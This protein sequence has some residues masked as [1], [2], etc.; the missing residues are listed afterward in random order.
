MKKMLFFLFVG[1]IFVAFT[2]VSHAS[3]GWCGNIWPLHDATV[4]DNVDVGVYFQIWK[5][6]VTTPAGQGAGIGASLFY[7]PNGGPYTEVAMVYNTDVG[8]ND[9]YT[10]NIPSSAL[11]G[12]EIW[13]YCEGYD[14][15]DASACTD[16]Q[17][18]NGHV[19]PHKLNITGTLDH[20]VAVIF[21]MCLPP[22]GHP[23]YDP[24]P[25]LVC[26]IGDHPEIGNWVS[27]V[28]IGQPCE[29]WSPRFYEVVVLFEAGSNPYVEYKYQ[30]NDCT[31][32]ESGG[33]HSIFIDDSDVY[34]QVPW[35]DHFS[36]YEGEDCS[37]CPVPV[38]ETSWGMIKSIYK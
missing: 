28:P 33:N 19:P 31:T 29:I 26:I 10:A 38:E 7:G 25:G 11:T 17:D 18:Q 12:P 21:T 15:T 20:D 24:A 34:Y 5:D 27:G 23:D 14:Y 36:W 2:G 1:V 6:G 9:E 16:G 30:K 37:S 32:W 13:F 4:A 22:E 3:I 35:T 8:S